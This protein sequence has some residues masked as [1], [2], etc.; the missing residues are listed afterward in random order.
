MAH[1]N[2]HPLCTTTFIDCWSNAT[3]HTSNPCMEGPKG[4]DSAFGG[5]RPK[6]HGTP[7]SQ[8]LWGAPTYHGRAGVG[9]PNANAAS[10]KAGA[11]CGAKESMGATLCWTA[12]PL[13]S[14]PVGVGRAP[15]RAGACD[16]AVV[17]RPKTTMP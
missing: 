13:G 12:E 17:N 15:W 3:T 4:I 9:T 1:A 6:R 5:H 2:T 8:G 10:P 11:T 16:G 7:Q 14:L